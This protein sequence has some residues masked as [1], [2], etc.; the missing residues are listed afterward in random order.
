MPL[1]APV[2]ITNWSP[3]ST[4]E[5]YLTAKTKQEVLGIGDVFDL[6][7]YY[8]TNKDKKQLK[9]GDSAYYIVPSDS[10]YYRTTNE[11]FVHFKSYETALIIKQYRG[12][13][14]CRYITV[15]RM[16]GYIKDGLIRRQKI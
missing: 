5:F 7:Q 14:F 4:I 13:V 9:G 12:G 16:R 6:H 2:V 3:G 1:Q 11:I 15:Y 10:F 8:W